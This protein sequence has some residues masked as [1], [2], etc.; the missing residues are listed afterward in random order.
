MADDFD[1]SDEQDHDGS[2]LD[3]QLDR[4]LRRART[5]DEAAL[6]D[7]LN[8]HRQL[9]KKM[10]A[11]HLGDAIQGR[12]ADSDVVQQSLLSAVR[13][14]NSFAGSTLPQFEAWLKQIHRRNLMDAVRDHAVY[15]KRATRQESRQ[16]DLSP[17]DD[18]RA[19]SPSGV[20]MRREADEQLRAAL[21]KLPENYRTAVEM[22]HLYD[23][24]L[25]E[26]AERLNK[27]RAAAAGDLKRGLAMLR[28]LLNPGGDSR[29]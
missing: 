29:P 25:A 15:Q 5:G 27:S 4:L 2:A 3:G 23:C 14:F 12:L 17:L 11:G 20:A 28:E 26:I 16:L 10:S 8:C 22:R 21:L 18:H 24:S 19:L 13:N 1:T 6:G 7:L 9:L